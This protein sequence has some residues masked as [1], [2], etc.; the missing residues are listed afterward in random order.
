MTHMNGD[1]SDITQEIE[2]LA[3][4]MAANSHIALQ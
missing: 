4:K 2:V 3:Q 1:Y